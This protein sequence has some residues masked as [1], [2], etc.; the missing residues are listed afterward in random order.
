MVRVPM[1]A[2]VLRFAR[3]GLNVGYFSDVDKQKVGDVFKTGKP[4]IGSYGDPIVRPLQSSLL[5]LH[6]FGFHTHATFIS[7]TRLTY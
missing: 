3:W 6:D 5:P 1:T 7:S 4:L 2:C